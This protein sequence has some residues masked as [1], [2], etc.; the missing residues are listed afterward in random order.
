MKPIEDAF[1]STGFRRVILPGVVLMIGIH[2]VLSGLARRGLT[3]YGITDAPV[4][5]IAE[6]IFF[7]LL[8]S[9]SVNWIYYVYEGIKL[10]WLTS[11]ARRWNEKHLKAAQAEYDGLLK[12][13]PYNDLIDEAEKLQIALA[14]EILLDYPLEIGSSGPVRRCNRPTVLG[15]II[16]A[17]E[18]Y[19]TSRYGADGIFY[20]FHLLALAPERATKEFAEN[21][22]FAESLVL[23][24]FAGAV[25]ALLNL[26]IIAGFALGYVVSC[27]PVVPIPLTVHTA[28]VLAIVG[29]VVFLVFYGLA[30][31]A[32][33]E[34]GRVFR[35]VVDLGIKD[36]DKWASE[37]AAPL[38]D[39]AQARVKARKRYLNALR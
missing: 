24:S 12:G 14:Y 23:T 20:W 3:T 37:T 26:G 32:H 38:D 6:V 35:T 16:A 28:V 9:S 17:Y 10:P 8:L 2:P 15:N 22:A 7:G 39:S 25:V 4:T 1:S 27:F 13:R 5:L 11:P 31:P 34:V 21:Y 30:L 19:S 33:R 18:G 29:I 36:L